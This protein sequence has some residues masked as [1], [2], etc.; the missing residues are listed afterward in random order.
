[1]GRKISAMVLR[2]PRVPGRYQVGS[3]R[4]LGKRILGGSVQ[5]RRYRAGRIH[6]VSL[7]DRWA[8]RESESE[9]VGY[10]GGFI[11]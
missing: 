2:V 9:D 6:G 5:A 1:M 7:R 11:W 10:V 8:D 3:R 4:Q